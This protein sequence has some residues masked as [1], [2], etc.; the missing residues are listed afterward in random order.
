[1]VVKTIRAFCACEEIDEIVIVTSSPYDDFCREAFPQAK[2]VLGG[3]ERQDSVYAALKETGEDMDYVLV[4]DGAR[5]FVRKETILS[6]I[7]ETLANGAAICTVRVKDTIREK[8]HTLDRSKLYAVQT[9]QGFR[10]EILLTAF[11][12]AMEDG[13]Y[14]TDEASLVE[15]LGITVALAEGDYGNI[16]I[17]TR[18][19]MPVERRVGTG[20]D[21]HRLTEGRKLIL[22]GVEIPYEKGLLGHSD[23]DVL[24]HAAMDA[25]LG[26]AALGDIGKL[27]PD[28]DEKYKGI[29]SI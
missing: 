16:K 22:G 25:I 13:V 5:P 11:E 24:V 1:M 8:D 17:T 3:K 29:S 7:K 26:A 21:V 14:G 20:Y 4:H 28:S 2:V 6:L 23:A 9:P 10:R 18:E 12:Q 15:R 19:D 27:F